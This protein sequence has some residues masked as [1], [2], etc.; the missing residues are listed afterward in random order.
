MT[1]DRMEAYSILSYRLA[2]CAVFNHKKAGGRERAHVL[3]WTSGGRL[4]KTCPQFDDGQCDAFRRLV[5]EYEPIKL[6]E[7]ER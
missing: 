1:S 2:G 3:Y 5:A 6:I 4:C 7:G